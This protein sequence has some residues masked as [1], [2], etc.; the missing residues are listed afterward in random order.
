MKIDVPYFSQK[1]DVEAEEWKGRACGIT[2]LKMALEYAVP[3]TSPSIDKLIEEALYLGGYE[4]AGWK[5]DVLILLAHNHGVAAYR[6]EYKSRIIDLAKKV[7]SIAPFESALTDHGIKKMAEAVETGQPVI[8]S[9]A[10]RFQDGGENHLVV[11]TGTEHE[12]DRL[13]GFYYHEPNETD[14]NEGMH[15]FVSTDTFR[16]Y[17]RKFAL[18]IEGN[19]AA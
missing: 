1:L 6:E 10:G 17:W 7:S 11:L 3:R 9:V 8:A 19:I 15:K 14:R 5:H 4:K 12:G 16:K 18:F 13:A 2:C